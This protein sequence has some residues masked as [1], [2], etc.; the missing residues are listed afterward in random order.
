MHA[1]P[2][3]LSLLA[4]LVVLAG[5][6]PSERGR[7]TDAIVTRSEQGLVLEMPAC[8]NGGVGLLDIWV[9]QSQHVALRAAQSRPRGDRVVVI[10]IV[11]VAFASKEFGSEVK[12]VSIAGSPRFR[13]GSWVAGSSRACRR[14]ASS[15]RGGV[16]S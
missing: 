9:D 3:A 7:A 6:E 15:G 1:K 10:E 11:P 2:L 4:A 16:G 14:R 12:M 13:V 5:C 8:G